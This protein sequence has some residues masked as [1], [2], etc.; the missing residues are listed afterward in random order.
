[1]ARMNNDASHI[2]EQVLLSL[3]N[4]QIVGPP[5]RYAKM[6]HKFLLH[7]GTR[8]Y[9]ET[10]IQEG[11]LSNDLLVLITPEDVKQFLCEKAYG[12]RDPEPNDFLTSCRANTLVVYKKAL[13]WFLPRQSQPWDKVGRVWNPTRS[14]LVNSAIEKVQKYEV[15]KQGADSQCRCPIE[16]QEYI[17]KLELLK[18]AAHDSTAGSVVTT[19]VLKT[20]SLISLQWHTISC[21]D[22]MRHFCFSDITSNPSFEFALSCQKGRWKGG[23]QMVDTYIDINLPV[24]D[25]MAAS[26]L[27]RPD[28]A[29]KYI[30]RRD[31]IS[32]DWLVQQVV[33]GAGQVSSTE[34]VSTLSLPLLWV[35]FEDYRVERG[36]GE[37]ANTYIPILHHKLKEHILE[38]YNWHWGGGTRWRCIKTDAKPSRVSNSNIITTGIG[39]KTSRRECIRY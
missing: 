30:L 26:K 19:K 31:T 13:S 15:H 24:P 21:I 29:C 8:D 9:S 25:A 23:K 2:D 39:P 1:M 27:C 35:A 34:M 38:A 3:P 16:Y 22:D 10:D 36:G 33:S 11:L 6:M 17:Q 4:R 20:I 37:T 14:A 5:K 12:H 28:G 32:K 7:R 18:K